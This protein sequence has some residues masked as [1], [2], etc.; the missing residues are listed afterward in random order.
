MGR[1]PKREGHDFSRAVRRR[2]NKPALAAGI[3]STETPQRHRKLNLC[4]VQNKAVIPKPRAF[5]SGARDLPRN[6]SEGTGRVPL[7]ITSFICR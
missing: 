4:N 2:R 1:F 5:T 7:C 3:T 6:E